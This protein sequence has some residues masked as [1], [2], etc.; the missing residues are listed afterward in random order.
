M[1]EGIDFPSMA[2]RVWKGFEAFTFQN[3]PRLGFGREAILEVLEDV[4]PRIE[5][6]W[7]VYKVNRAIVAQT[8]PDYW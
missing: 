3:L 6:T 7:P 8:P 5:A 4:K 1:A 2:E